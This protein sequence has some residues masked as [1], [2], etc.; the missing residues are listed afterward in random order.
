MKRDR[1]IQWSYI[2]RRTIGQPAFKDDRMGASFAL[3][4]TLE[5]LIADGTIVELSGAQM[6][7][8]YQYTGKAYFVS[9]LQKL[10]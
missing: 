4:R 9:D 1:V 5:L 2:S 10:G 7:S 8:R 6:Q 3:K